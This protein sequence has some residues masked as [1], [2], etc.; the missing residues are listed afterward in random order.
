MVAVFPDNKFAHA[1]IVQKFTQKE[2]YN[3]E[4]KKMFTTVNGGNGEI[5]GE[6]G[7]VFGFEI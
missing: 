4:V 2:A 1:F 5:G 7:E 6:K 3:L